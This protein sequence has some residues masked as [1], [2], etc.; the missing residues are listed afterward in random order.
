MRPAARLRRH[1]GRTADS[2]DQLEAAARAAA[3][4]Y[5][6]SVEG[7]LREVGV[8][9]WPHV[10]FGVPA[11]VTRAVIQELDADVLVL[12]DGVI[13]RPDDLGAVPIPVLTSGPRCLRSA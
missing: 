13:R 4:A 6:A 7:R 12:T 2:R 11:P 5:L 10:R 8:T 3:R 1:R 9:V